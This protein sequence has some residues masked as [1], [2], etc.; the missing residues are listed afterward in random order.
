MYIYIYIFMHMSNNT[1]RGNLNA[2]FLA[3]SEV[4]DSTFVGLGFRP[5][6]QEFILA[7]TFQQKAFDCS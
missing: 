7:P 1:V 6:C 2:A 3:G 4:W 5:L